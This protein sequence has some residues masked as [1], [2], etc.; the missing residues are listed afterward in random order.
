MKIK[1]VR[2]TL[3][4]LISIALFGASVASA[5][6]PRLVGG[7]CN[8]EVGWGVEPALEDAD[9]HVVLIIEDCGGASV[10]AEDIDVNV[11]ILRL[12]EDSFDAQIKDQMNLGKFKAIENFGSR[13]VTPSKNGAYGFILNG[14]I[15]GRVIDH[16]KFVCGGGSQHEEESFDCV[17]DPTV[18]PGPALNRYVPN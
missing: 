6:E 4:S 18:F 7:D 12:R 10:A 3:F 14:A 13:Q 1:T 8:V 16:V 15:A 17:V 9:N 11:T 5:H 2:N